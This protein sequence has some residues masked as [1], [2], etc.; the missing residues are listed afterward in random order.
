MPSRRAEDHGSM[1][2]HGF[3][4]PGGHVLELACMAPAAVPD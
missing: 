4:D 3:Q 1:Y 2:G